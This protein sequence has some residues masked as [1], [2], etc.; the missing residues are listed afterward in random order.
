MKDEDNGLYT[1]CGKSFYYIS[2]MIISDIRILTFIIEAKG[3]KW[4]YEIH[5]LGYSKIAFLKV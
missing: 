4:K 3:E 1:K 2:N 5:L